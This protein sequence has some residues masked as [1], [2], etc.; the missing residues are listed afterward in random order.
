MQQV[1]G[2]KQENVALCRKRE[3]ANLDIMAHL[4]ILWMTVLYRPAA[5]IVVDIVLHALQLSF[6]IENPVVISLLPES[7][8]VAIDASFLFQQTVFA[9]ASHFEAVDNDAKMNRNLLFDKYHGMKVVG[10]DLMSPYLYCGIELRY[11]QKGF[12]YSFSQWAAFHPCLLR[13]TIT[14]DCSEQMPVSLNNKC[15]HIDAPRLIV[16]SDASSFH[17]WL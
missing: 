10:H 2:I 5:R 6:L 8:Q 16:M 3:I 13:H 4:E 14:S 11:V 7:W 1:W 17:R 9:V 15:Y 12:Y